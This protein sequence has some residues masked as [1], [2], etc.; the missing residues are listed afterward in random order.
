M[1]DLRNHEREFVKQLKA[2]FMIAEI[3]QI[4]RI[5]D[6]FLEQDETKIRDLEKEARENL[7]EHH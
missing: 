7:R 2:S 6:H 4:K 3:K 5:E 1:E